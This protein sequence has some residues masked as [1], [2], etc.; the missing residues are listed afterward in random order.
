MEFTQ[1]FKQYLAMI[2]TILLFSINFSFLNASAATEK[3]KVG[4]FEFSGYH[5]IE[6][7]GQRSGYGY[8]FLQKIACYSDWTYDYRAYDA[9]Y[10]D[11]LEMLENGEIDVLTSVTKTPER[12]E[13][14]L[15]SD[16]SI[17]TNSTMFTVKSGNQEVVAGNYDTYDGLTIGML[18][19]NSKNDVFKEFSKEKNFSYHAKY[20]STED[21]LINALQTDEVEG[22]VTGSLR[23]T[24]NE[25]LVETLDENPFYIVVSKSRPDLMK[26]I[27]EAIHELN[28][29]EP[30]WR[31]VLHNKYY[32]LDSNGNVMLEAE[33]RKYLEHLCNS[34]KKLKV[35]VNPDKS[36]YSYFEN[37]EA[38]G[39]F[40][41]IFSEIAEKL[42]LPYE[43]INPESRENYYEI[44]ERKEA[45][46][47]LDFAYNYYLAESE[48]Y[49]L[50]SPYLE[51]TYTRLTRKDNKEN[52][53]KIAV[54]KHS[55]IFTAYLQ[56]HYAP[57]NFVY[58]ENVAE[59]VQA[60][61]E[62]TADATIL[63]S[64][65]AEQILQQDSRNSFSLALIG[66]IS[67]EYTVGVNAERNH[68]LLTILNKEFSA[69]QQENLSELIMKEAD[70]IRTN[71]NT[72]FISFLYNNPIYG[73]IILIFVFLFISICLILMLRI[74]NQRE[75]NRKI[76]EITQQYKIKEKELS[77]ALALADQANRAKTTF[78]NN[79]SHD[80]R[81]P[82]NAIIGFTGLAV[83]H[84]DNRERAEDYL[85]KI[86][87]SSNHLLSL[88]NDVL[89]MSRIESG[90]VNIDEKPENLAEILHGIRNIIQ[91]DVHAKQLELFIETVNITNE[92]IY[93]DKLRLNQILLNLLSNSIKFTK[94]GGTVALQVTQHES[95]DEGKSIY[96]FQ[97]KDNGIGMSPEFAET[98][99]E[100]FTRE[101]TSTVSGIQG[102]GLGMSITKNIVDMMHGTIEVHSE[103]NKGT[104][105]IVKIEFR[106]HGEAVRPTKIAELQGVRSLVVDDDVISCQSISRML[107]QA[108]LRPEWSMYG[109]EAVVRTAEALDM[110]DPYQVYILDWSMP[111]MNGIETARQIRKLVGDQAPVILLSAYDWADVE[112]E[113]REA[114]VTDFISKPLFA[115]DL[116]YVLERAVGRV[117]ERET[118]TEISSDMFVNKR[119]L[120][121]EDNELNR[122]IAVEIL[123]GKQFIVETAENGQIAYDMVK[124][125][126]PGY[127]DLVL[128]D[129]QMPVMDGYTATRNIRQLENVK[130]ANIPII[131]MTADAFEEDR[132]KALDAG[133]NGHLAKPIDINEMLKYLQRILSENSSS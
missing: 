103:Q 110:G 87:Q 4:F 42:S 80:I 59:C 108:G 66:E 19:G 63:Y 54:M 11:N 77:D 31:N 133:M 35:L 46:I 118:E 92:D 104:E 127:Y 7:N 72:D 76:D 130:L 96:E 13:K 113:A 68:Y 70:V 74:R 95:E 88:I 75:L 69:L 36:P 73:V 85:S 10:A 15:F 23:A 2:L 51:T 37:G 79:M 61:S 102:T 9:S 41:E 33:E 12:E 123:H 126:E 58:F 114:G 16:E 39:I 21:E 91:A 60:V 62:G 101:R 32:T 94:P 6:E 71:T 47:V 105:F 55:D 14:F 17:G 3:I 56:S 38:K 131:A 40:P 111:D 90:N 116:H 18:E 27:N 49:K 115:S 1:R 84:L 97:V 24:Q 25:W 119:I 50:T 43:Y 28:L 52:I 93:C 20:Y 132:K 57:E 120:L 64:Y 89:D 109:R 83:A 82:M 45:D 117:Q 125:S 81:T 44:R 129:V 128:M 86:A 67:L 124:N 99:F 100:P 22:A 107:R 78:L 121:A 65:T 53:Q 30:D 34:G 26:K 122:E 112:N 48:G 98:I 8:E 106:Y 29:Q 5:E